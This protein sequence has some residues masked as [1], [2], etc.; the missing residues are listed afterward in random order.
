[1]KRTTLKTKPTGKSWRTAQAY[2]VDFSS[3]YLRGINQRLPVSGG[4]MV[5][6]VVGRKPV[7]ICTPITHI[8]FRMHRNEW[9]QSPVRG[10][11]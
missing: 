11:V 4:R 2:D 6:A 10:I 5:W 7:R 3:I 9:D 1:M 8:K